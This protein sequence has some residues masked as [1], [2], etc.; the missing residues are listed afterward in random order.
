MAKHNQD[1]NKERVSIGVHS[2][3]ITIEIGNDTLKPVAT[4]GR[5]RTVTQKE[6]DDVFE[7][8]CQGH[9]QVSIAALTGL[10]KGTVQK[11]YRE[12]DFSSKWKELVEPFFVEAKV[13]ISEVGFKL[14][15]RWLAIAK[16]PDSPTR[17]LARASESLEKIFV[18]LEKIYNP[19]AVDGGK[20]GPHANYDMTEVL[21]AILDRK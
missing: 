20:N 6:I 19:K 17:D 16:D 14:V 1:N 21:K 18:T 10:P 3:S 9:T 7:L 2:K 13:C 5:P 8:F 12:Q 4:T 11:I 15:E